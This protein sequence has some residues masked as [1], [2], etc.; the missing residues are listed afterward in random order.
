MR[1]PSTIEKE[2]GAVQA[3]REVLAGDESRAQAAEREAQQALIAGAGDVGTVTSAQGTATALAAAVAAVDARLSELRAELAEARAG[4]QAAAT[5]ARA[6]ELRQQREALQGEWAAQHAD[7]DAALRQT[8]AS[9]HD[10][11]QRYADASRELARLVPAGATAVDRG[12][13][14]P[15]LE[16]GESIF[17][18]LQ[19]ANHEADRQRRKAGLR[20]AGERE[21]ERAAAQRKAA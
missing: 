6:A 3:R 1:T 16:F 11:G 7:A 8:V 13:V 15:A 19:H 9:L 18:A 2:I 12:L 14:A 17:T 21:R 20:A 5:R 10:I 4:E